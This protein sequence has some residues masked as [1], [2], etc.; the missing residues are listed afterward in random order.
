MLINI[1]EELLQGF[2]GRD[3]TLIICHR[4][5]HTADHD[6]LLVMLHQ[7]Q[8]GHKVIHAGAAGTGS[9][10]I[11]PGIHDDTGHILIAITNGPAF[12]VRAADLIGLG[13]KIQQTIQNLRRKVDTITADFRAGCSAQIPDFRHLHSQTDLMQGLLDFLFYEKD[14]L[15]GKFTDTH[16]KL[17]SSFAQIIFS[18]L[19]A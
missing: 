6:D 12:A 10:V 8:I 13:C 16:K 18:L 11:D 15:L 1:Q 2:I 14:L 17:L 9:R 3:I 19:L 5:I 7:G 4:E